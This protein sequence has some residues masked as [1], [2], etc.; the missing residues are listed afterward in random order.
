MADAEHPPWCES[1]P[2]GLLHQ[3]LAAAEEEGVALA[4]ENALQRYDAAA[5][6]RI[7]ASALGR[8]AL[9]G[10]LDQLTFL[11]MGDL[12]FDNWPAFCGLLARLRDAR[13]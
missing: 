9:R 10:R 3:V 11:R 5:L 6:D 2:E 1:S 12:M 4:G 13:A 7:A 8:S